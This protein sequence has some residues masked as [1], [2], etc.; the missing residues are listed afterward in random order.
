MNFPGWGAPDPSWL[1]SLDSQTKKNVHTEVFEA[2]HGPSEASHAVSG[3][4]S[5]RKAQFTEL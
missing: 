1:A 4:L 2:Y 5:P 3:G